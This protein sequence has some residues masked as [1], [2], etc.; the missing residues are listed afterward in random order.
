MWRSIGLIFVLSF[1]GNLLYAQLITAPTPVPVTGWY[2]GNPN[3]QDGVTH[4]TGFKGAGALWLPW[5]Q[6]MAWPSIIAYAPSATFGACP[7]DGIGGDSSSIV[8]ITDD[9]GHTS[10]YIFGTSAFAGQPPNNDLATWGYVRDPLGLV[11]RYWDGSY[12][13]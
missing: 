4:G 8:P 11:V 6:T 9:Q 13:A 5:V 1:A 3:A 2:D 10:L 12:V 7:L